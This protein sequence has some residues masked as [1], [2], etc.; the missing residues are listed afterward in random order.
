MQ[1][2]VAERDKKRG[3]GGAE[4]TIKHSIIFTPPPPPPPPIQIIIAQSNLI[5]SL[6]KKKKIKTIVAS[7]I[8]EHPYNTRFLQDLGLFRVTLDRSLTFIF[9]DTH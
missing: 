6:S 5:V 2:V 4:K 7:Q 1:S 8:G 3:G 9:Q